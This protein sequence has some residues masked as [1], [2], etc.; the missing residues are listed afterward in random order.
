MIT[1]P[2]RKAPRILA[3][4]RRFAYNLF[5]REDNVANSHLH[6]E[7]EAT[8]LCNTRCLHCPREALTRP[9]GKMDLQTYKT[10]IDKAVASSKTF[11][12]VY[13]GLG[14]PLLNPLVYDFITYVDRRGRTSMVTN[15]SALTPKNVQRLIDSGIDQITMSFNG[16]EKEPY[17][18]MMGGLNFE[19]ARANLENAVRM[20]RDTQTIMAVNVSVT[21]QTRGNLAAI[22]QY[23]D[24]V[25]VQ[26]I[27]FSMCHSRCGML[28]DESVCDTPLPPSDKLRCDMFKCIMFVSWSGIVLSC[29]DDLAGTNEM[30]DLKVDSIE[31]ILERK[32]KI[33]SEGV[34]FDICN[35]CND[36]YRFTDDRLPGGRS[37]SDCIYDLYTSGDSH[38]SDK[39]SS[40]SE[41]LGVLTDQMNQPDH[42]MNDPM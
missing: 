11:C 35:L 15:G 8:N 29:Y 13:A 7:I 32:K 17:E 9:K 34:K 21:R 42:P 16:V 3:D 37:I 12:V 28:K 18:L 39:T 33:L 22:K 19:R 5:Q 2:E 25:G 1:T 41:W 27:Y 36:L 23:L 14:E 30:G 26:E 20:T 24:G 31:S 6:L 4:L 10:I 38:A 40:L